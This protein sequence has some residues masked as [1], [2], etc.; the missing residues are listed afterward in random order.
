MLVEALLM[1]ASDLCSS[2]KTWEMQL[3][4]VAVIY[5]E[6]HK[7]VLIGSGNS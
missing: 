5:Q 4:T 6:F 7:Q 3:E 1:T 2:A